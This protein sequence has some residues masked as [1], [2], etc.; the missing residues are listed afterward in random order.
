MDVKDFIEKGKYEW[1][2]QYETGIKRIDFE[3]V[4][5]LELINSLRYGI[6]SKMDSSELEGIIT[7]IEKYAEFHFI[8]E[9]NFMLRI[10]YPDFKVHQ[11][12]HFE[13]LEQ[14][15]LT[16]HCLVDFPEF[17]VFLSK[18]FVNHTIMEDKKISNYVRRNKIDVEKYWYNLNL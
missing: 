1:S 14:F 15:N 17:L 12:E 7:E 10:Q 11:N 6:E 18:W 16:K 13:L 3:H 2:K 9:E 8:S 5:F 4:V